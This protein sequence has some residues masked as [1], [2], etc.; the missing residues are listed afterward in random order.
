MSFETSQQAVVRLTLGLTEKF[1]KH[2]SQQEKLAKNRVKNKKYYKNN[3]SED[4]FDESL[5]YQSFESVFI[6]EKSLKTNILIDRYELKSFIGAGAFSCCILAVD[7]LRPDQPFRVIKK[8]NQTYEE[9][10]LQV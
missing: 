9:F 7:K 10:G 6:Q 2:I 8:M 3:I 1:K 5:K 4:K